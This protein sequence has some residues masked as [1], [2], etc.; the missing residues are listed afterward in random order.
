[1]TSVAAR[2]EPAAT[3]ARRASDRVYSAIPIVTV[4]V[5]LAGLCVWESWKHVSPWLFTDELELTQI[6]RAIAATGH[7]ARRGE[8]YGFH[9]LYAYLI[10]PAWL[11]HG[12][13]RAYSIAKYIG[14]FTM[15]TTVFPVYWLARLIVSARAALFAAAGATAIPAFAYSS[16]LVPEPLAYAWAA[17]CFFLIAKA[18]I[19]RSAPWIA[20]AVA[21]CIVAHWVRGEL[22][23]L[24]PIFALAALFLAW[25]SER[26]RSWRSTWSRWDWAG[27]VVLGIG[28]LILFSGIMSRSHT[29][30]ISTGYY[31]HRMIE[32]G[33]WAA[34][35]LTIGLGVLPVVAGLAALFR[36]RSERRTPE[37]RALTALV[38]ASVIGFGLY[39][40][41]KAAYLSTVFATRVEERN[42]IYVAPLLF[43]ATALWI[44][45]PR[46]RIV[47]LLA[48]AAFSGYL[49]TAPPYALDLVPYS[50]AFGLSVLA[51]ANRDLAF[52][53][54]GIQWLLLGALGVSLLLLLAPA[55]LGG[56]RH[57]AAAVVGATA[58]LVLAWNVAGQVSA[59][60]YSNQFS[61]TVLDNFPK[62]SNWLDRTTGG[63]GVVF[64]GQ[65]VDAGQA[66]AENL[67]EFW[68]PSLKQVWSLDGTAPGPGSHDITPDLVQGNGRLFP[69]PPYDYMLVDKRIDLVGRIIPTPCCTPWKLYR[70]EHP[71]RLAHSVTGL[72]QDGW[73]GADSAYSQ[74]AT[75]GGKPGFVVVTVSRTAWRGPDKPGQVTIEV[76]RLIEGKDKQPHMGLVTAVRRWT[77]H[78]GIGRAFRIPTPAPPIR[79]QVDISPTFSP[80]DYPGSS[81][82]RPLGAQV[83]FS[84]VPRP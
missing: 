22:T 1:M 4:F 47:P 70:I 53:S 25:S 52:A 24:L 26:A 46:L 77:V 10:A 71:L 76:G 63:Q 58:L 79:V 59:S 68:N 23:L 36:P 39:T 41:A 82:A 37:L 33:L 40:A 80:A 18:L 83:S 3:Q 11:F 44:D 74:Y 54:G 60:V 14:V 81:D 43:V 21:A 56:R 12:S 31:R 7:A 50:D 73:A 13:A 2:G 19:S 20:G 75:P 69:D 78:S 9:S 55:V 27:A 29:S 72:Y 62:P 67:L 65:K 6:S 57:A 8:P 30:L 42:L 38:A 5:C 66:F 15:A 35:A 32:Y 28:A 48:A 64:L 61:Q 16:M 34:G 17:L 84:F 45:R 51:T 49:V